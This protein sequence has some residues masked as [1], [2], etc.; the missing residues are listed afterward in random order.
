MKNQVFK[1]GY[2]CK[3]LKATITELNQLVVESP[4]YWA[5]ELAV[6]AVGTLAGIGSML[7]SLYPQGNLAEV[8]QFWLNQE[9]TAKLSHIIVSGILYDLDN[10]NFGVM[11]A[12]MKEALV[13]QECLIPE[14]NIVY[15]SK[16]CY[17]IDKP[18]LDWI[19]ACIS[20]AKPKVILSKLLEL[21]L[22]IFMDRNRAEE[23]KHNFRALTCILEYL[24]EKRPE[25]VANGLIS[26]LNMKTPGRGARINGYKFFMKSLVEIT[27]DHFILQQKSL[28]TNKFSTLCMYWICWKFLWTQRDLSLYTKLESK[29]VLPLRRN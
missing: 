5:K 7:G 1:N 14:K 25:L 20:I 15:G 6:W 27:Y 9:V 19:L 24:V 11:D 17:H 10:G 3:A 18:Y 4:K 16:I 22:V 29:S 2:P 8:T 21:G 26:L 12:L 13:H 23:K 28:R